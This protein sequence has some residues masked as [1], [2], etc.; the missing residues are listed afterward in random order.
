MRSHT[1]I[2]FVAVSLLA[3]AHWPLNSGVVHACSEGTIAPGPDEKPA[4]PRR[5]S[6]DEQAGHQI[7][8]ID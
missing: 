6:D 2:F 5:L 4:K 8:S 3:F 7:D 1:P